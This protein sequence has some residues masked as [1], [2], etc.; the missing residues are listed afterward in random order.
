MGEQLLREEKAGLNVV[1]Q[2]AM[3]VKKDSGVTVGHLPKKIAA[4]N[5]EV[6]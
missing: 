1:D 5:E 3:A 6:R 4:H 2:Y